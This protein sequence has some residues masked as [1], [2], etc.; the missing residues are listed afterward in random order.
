MLFTLSRSTC[1]TLHEE[2][3]LRPQEMQTI[4]TNYKITTLLQLVNS[5]QF[6]FLSD[7]VPLGFKWMV[8]AIELHL[9][10]D[11]QIENALHAFITIQ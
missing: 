5:P 6:G 8:R 4:T 9:K 3:A 2:N 11:T 1:A 10:K 7:A